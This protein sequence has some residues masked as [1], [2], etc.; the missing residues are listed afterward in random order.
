VF[1]GYGQIVSDQVVTVSDWD[2]KLPHAINTITIDLK[3]ALEKVNDTV[4]IGQI[5]IVVTPSFKR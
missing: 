5:A 4:Y 1:L 3:G 2:R